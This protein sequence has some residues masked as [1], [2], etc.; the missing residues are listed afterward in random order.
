MVL[1]L[2]TK[3]L[4]LTVNYF[5]T[6]RNLAGIFSKPL[7]KPTQ[8]TLVS[9]LMTWAFGLSLAQDFWRLWTTSVK[10][11]SIWGMRKLRYSSTRFQEALPEV[12]SESINHLACPKFNQRKPP[13]RKS[14]LPE[15]EATGTHKMESTKRIWAEHQPNLWQWAKEKENCLNANYLFF[16]LSRFFKIWGQLSSIFLLFM[17]SLWDYHCFRQMYSYEESFFSMSEPVINV[18]TFLATASNAADIPL[19]KWK[20]HMLGPWIDLFQGASKIVLDRQWNFSTPVAL[21]LFLDNENGIF[22]LLFFFCSVSSHSYLRK[23]K[24]KK[25]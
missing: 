11:P 14:Q 19:L 23:K 5:S 12:C 17:I 6:V 15:Q 16:S 20:S 25:S 7:Q 10:V 4:G 8:G 3:Q 22:H 21:S 2:K 9:M 13:G 24:K 18:N 1:G